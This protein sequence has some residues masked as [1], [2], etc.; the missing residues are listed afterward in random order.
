MINLLICGWLK[1]STNA[2]TYAEIDALTKKKKKNHTHTDTLS[3]IFTDALAFKRVD[4]FY[5]KF[6]NVKN[7]KHILVLYISNI[8]DQSSLM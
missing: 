3:L 8:L 5:C 7:D 1:A 4:L 2:Y 6:R